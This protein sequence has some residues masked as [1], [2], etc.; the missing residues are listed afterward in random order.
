M[1][2]GLFSMMS[3]TEWMKWIYCANMSL[4]VVA[5]SGWL[6]P[7]KRGIRSLSPGCRAATVWFISLRFWSP[8]PHPRWNISAISAELGFKY[9]R[10]FLQHFVSDGD[11]YLQ[12]SNP[13]CE[14]LPGFLYDGD[15]ALHLQEPAS[16]EPTSDD[17]LDQDALVR[18]RL[19][20]GV[21]Q[22]QIMG[23]LGKKWNKQ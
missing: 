17:L 22:P 18:E 6:P 23:I 13:L 11:T 4:K 7:C 19:V 2:L 14:F 3:S 15:A 9:L 12:I 16:I 20:S 21:L 5:S 1:L 10:S 8:S